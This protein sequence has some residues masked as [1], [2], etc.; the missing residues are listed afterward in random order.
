MQT[1]NQF[2][3]P[4][5]G[6]QY[7]AD[8]N[9]KCFSFPGHNIKCRQEIK[10]FFPFQDTNTMQ[11]VIQKRFSFPG[12]NIKCRREIKSFFPFQDTNTMQTV[13]QKHFSFLEHHYKNADLKSIHFSI[14]RIPL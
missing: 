11:T 5:P 10:S 2:I 13:I 7:I 9:T 12:H 4:I 8:S 6:Y 1:G 14:A 3:F